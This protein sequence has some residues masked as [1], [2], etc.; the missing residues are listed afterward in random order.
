MKNSNRLLNAIFCLITVVFAL[1][2]SNYANATLT[3]IDSSTSVWWSGCPYG[4][5][6]HHESFSEGIASSNIYHGTVGLETTVSYQEPANKVGKLTVDNV[7]SWDTK[8]MISDSPDKFYTVYISV[9]GSGSLEGNVKDVPDA[10]DW[11]A[12][13]KEW[14]EINFKVSGITHKSTGELGKDVWDH[15]YNGTDN[16]SWANPKYFSVGHYTGGTLIEIWGFFHT[17][18]YVTSGN[19]YE[20]SA[21][22]HFFGPGKGLTF[23]LYAL[24]VPEPSGW[25]MMSIGIFLLVWWT[26][27]R[28]A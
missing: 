16:V 9:S 27:S 17:Q 2:G 1:L 28:S 19:D 7:L 13:P 23:E 12:F 6:T 8:L 3:I 10:N 20:Q 14:Y 5:C 22:A 21:A 18:A 15:I 4:T 26:R 24:P 11:N 25:F